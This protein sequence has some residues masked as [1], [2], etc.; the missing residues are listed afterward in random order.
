MS[1]TSVYRFKFN[2][3]FVNLLNNFSKI[4]QYDTRETYNEAWKE[5]I[6][7]NTSAID[8][9]SERLTQLGYS[10]DIKTKMYKA[11]RYYFREL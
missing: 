3:D 5:W 1:I 7:E 10:G 8:I 6:Q 4:H 9:E 2:D 11:A